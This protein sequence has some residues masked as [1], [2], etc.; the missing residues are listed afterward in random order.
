MEH[1]NVPANR[2]SYL[3]PVASRTI[4]AIRDPRARQRS[5]VSSALFEGF[6]ITGIC[7]IACI[8][9]AAGFVGP[10]G[11]MGA[12]A[13]QIALVVSAFLA[14]WMVAGSAHA[15]LRLP[16]IL[17][18]DDRAVIESAR[19]R[20]LNL[21]NSGYG[22]DTD[23]TLGHFAR[24]V[25]CNLDQW[26]GGRDLLMRM[27]AV[28]VRHADAV[29]RIQ[30]DA[31][32]TSAAR[33]IARDACFSMIAEYRDRMGDRDIDGELEDLS[34]DCRAIASGRPLDARTASY[35]PTARIG[36]IISTAERMLADHPDL[37]DAQGA[38]V[39]DLVRIH[40][41]RLLERHRVAAESASAKDLEA[42]DA[43]L[44]IGIEK[45]RESVQEAA[46]AI[47]DDAMRALSTELRFLSLRRGT[48]PLLAAVS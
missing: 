43:Q 38:R 10:H 26:D 45:V 17:T 33:G 15:V 1:R 4:D 13:I 35:A 44:D 22:F 6:G 18:L 2:T 23:E 32:R 8:A 16:A 37:V 31:S 19:S 41:P 14:S 24:T 40:V 36:R 47:H 27:D 39:D 28:A 20:V 42:V 12:S 9:A 21:I 11:I 5:I 34:R 25:I 46:D 7:T 29:E 48:T 30:H 3:R